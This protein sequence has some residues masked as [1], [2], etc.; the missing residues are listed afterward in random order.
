MKF[1]L[2]SLA[3]LLTFSPMAFTQTDSGAENIAKEARFLDENKARAG[4][5]V[6]K[7]GLQ[8]E[9]VKEGAGK[10]PAAT[11]TVTVNYEGKLLNGTVFDSSYKR[12]QPAT[13]PLNRVIPG[14]TEGVQLMK[15]GATYLF[16]IPS[17]LAYGPQ[18]APGAI[19]PNECLIFKVELISI[20]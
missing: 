5:K 8:Y 10:S 12:G 7:S 15:T 2:A 17:K 3:L 18:G 11:D 4:V 13:F 6:T 19:G 9:V 20:Q 14:W 1:I 16:Y